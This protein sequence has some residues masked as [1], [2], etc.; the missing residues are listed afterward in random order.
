MMK[1]TRRSQPSEPTST[2]DVEKRSPVI[3]FGVAIVLG[4]FAVFLLLVAMR[5]GMAM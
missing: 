4:L 3:G 5:I 2:I 1:T